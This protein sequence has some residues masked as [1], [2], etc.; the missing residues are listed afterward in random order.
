MQT[1]KLEG[2]PCLLVALSVEEG[3]VGLKP[4]PLGRGHHSADAGGPWG[5]GGMK[6]VLQ[7]LEKL[8]AGFS[9]QEQLRVR[10]LLR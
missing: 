7:V 5:W 4:R 8:S 1:Q 3:P 9:S 2:G 6:Q 10:P